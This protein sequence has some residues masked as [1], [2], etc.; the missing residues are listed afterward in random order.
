MRLVSTKSLKENTYLA[1]PIINDSGQVLLKQGVLLS[2]RMIQRLI[3]LGITF[4]YIQDK[5]TEDIESTE[6][7]AAKVRVEATNTIKSEFNQICKDIKLQK[8]FHNDHLGQNFSK[9]IR[10]I[11]AEVKGNPKAISLLSDVYLYD[12]YIFTHSLNVT[13]Y[14]LALAIKL[15]YNEKQLMEIG[16]GAILHDVGKMAIPT[17]ILNKPGRLDPE[18]F[19]IIKTHAQVG[20]E[21][22]KK[23]PNLSLLT[24][25]CAFQHHER[26]NGSGYP[27]GIKGDEIHPYAKIIG[28]CDVFD[29]VTCN[30]VYRKAMLPHEA[31]EL[32][33]SG[34]GTLYD[35]DLVEAFAKS[36]ALYPVGITVGLSD[37]R[38]GIVLKQNKELSTRPIIRVISENNQ[39]VEP[40][41][42]DLMK[43]VNVTITSCEAVLANE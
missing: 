5:L 19:S 36:I 6:G 24:A 23:Q 22:L 16:L 39:Q 27:R 9:V 37:G 17:K 10:S 32:L 7:I 8:S 3:D 33:Y 34:V 4:V 12:S 14:T 15:K 41:D 35:K 11:L 18:E 21:I 28:I 2:S 26:I 25:H 42:L 31:I 29:A 30:R 40:Y 1:K 43:Q 20:Y 38:E 13:I